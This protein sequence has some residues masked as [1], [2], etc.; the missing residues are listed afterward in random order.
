MSSVFKVQLKLGQSIAQDDAKM[1]KE[2]AAI[3][4]EGQNG[5]QGNPATSA[6]YKNI[7]K[8]A[9]EVLNRGDANE[10]AAFG[11]MLRQID[12]KGK[13]NSAPAQALFMELG[14]IVTRSATNKDDWRLSLMQD[15]YMMID[16]SNE[17]VSLLSNI[18]ML[19]MHKGDSRL[20]LDR[21][22][23][24]SRLD[25][26]AKAEMLHAA[27][28]VIQNGT[29]EQRQALVEVMCAFSDL[30]TGPGNLWD[31]LDKIFTTSKDKAIRSKFENYDFVNESISEYLGIF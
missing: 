19:S 21:L 16:E 6:E 20:S 5:I 1:H 8:A 11:R 22:Q 18:K 13:P 10:I 3:W 14:N 31:S 15:T 25:K 17:K 23:N 29:D 9:I 12:A 24:F 30:S 27:I 26:N 2:Y 4:K 28:E 7:K